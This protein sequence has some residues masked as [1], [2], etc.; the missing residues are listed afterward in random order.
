[1]DF[2]PRFLVQ[3]GT[4]LA[5]LETKDVDAKVTQMASIV[6]QLWTVINPHNAM[7]YAEVFS[8]ELSPSERRPFGQALERELRHHDDYE[9]ELNSNSAAHCL[10]RALDGTPRDR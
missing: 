1:M 2:D 10:R 8:I 7:E 6:S 4:S 5:K 9:Q 3:V